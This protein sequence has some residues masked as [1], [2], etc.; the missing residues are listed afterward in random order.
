MNNKLIKLH[1]VGY[2]VKQISKSIAVF[3]KMG[4]ELKGDICFDND[5]KAE[6]CFID[7]NSILIELVAPT[8]DSDLYPLL[9]NYRN[10]PYHLCYE[11]KNLDETIIDMEKQGFLLFKSPQ[12]ALA[13][14]KNA[15][16]A[17]LMHRYIGM[18][19]LLQY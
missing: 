15:Y 6:I 16:V 13:I 1:H 3:N 14:S 7:S 4:F 8:S 12:K 10:Q 2:L 19:E 17:F 11:V 5:R 9:K 18:I